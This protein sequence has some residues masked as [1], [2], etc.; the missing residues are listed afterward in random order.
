MRYERWRILG[1]E[2]QVRL[3]D[4]M[5][6]LSTDMK[7]RAFHARAVDQAGGFHVALQ[8]NVMKPQ[9]LS[10]LVRLSARISVVNQKQTEIMRQH[11]A[12]GTT[13]EHPGVK[14]IANDPTLNDKEKEQLTSMYIE[15][16]SEQPMSQILGE[17]HAM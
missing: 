11:V 9:I 17:K 8:P 12:N 5:A 4:Y 14:C 3:H 15:A 1:A 6:R 7:H 16:V 2:M 10:K 13:N